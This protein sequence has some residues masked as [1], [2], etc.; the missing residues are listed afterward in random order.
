MQLWQSATLIFFL[1]VAAVAA[2]PGRARPAR[3]GH[4][5]AGVTAGLVFTLAIS[6]APYRPI[7]HDWVAP[8]VALLLGY[9][10]SGLLFVRPDPAQERALLGLDRRLTILETARRFP[11]ALATALETAYAG[12][13]PVI[14]F[15]LALHVLF[16][17]DPDPAWFW[18]IV[19]V[20]DFVCFGFLAWVQT[21]P[22]RTL[23]RCE[24][25]HSAVRR[26]NLGVIGT[27][28][29]QVNT[30]PSGHA[31]EALAAV[32]LVLGAPWPIVALMLLIALA[33]SAAAVFG[34]YH[35]AA[36][37]FAGWAVAVCV[38]MLIR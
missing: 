30:F 35:Y 6:A 27:A 7:L 13:Y 28:S 22:P 25:W 11:P 16:V 31:A 20:T 34:R 24:P 19:L 36:D 2:A 33:I 17:P 23:E 1:Y 29:I 32:L 4:L 18:S 38:W 14:P 21:R 3:L 8:P 5:Y 15:A 26:F 10:V 37:A 9:W 12:V